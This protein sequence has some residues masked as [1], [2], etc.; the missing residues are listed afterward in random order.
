MAKTR[1]RTTRAR[2]VR[3]G[4]SRPRPI[5]GRREAFAQ[6]YVAHHN[7]ARAAIEAGYAR[8][9][10]KVTGA[11]LLTN[12]NLRM[13]IAELDG[14]AAERAELTA[15]EVR[16]R[17]AIALRVSAADFFE[18]G[19][20]GQPQ[21]RRIETWPKESVWALE[22]LKVKRYEPVLAKDGSVIR[23]AFEVLEFKLP[24]RRGML[25]LTGR[26]TGAIPREA[27]A[28]GDEGVHFHFHGGR[29]GF[30]RPDPER[31]GKMEI[32]VGKRDG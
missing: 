29:M 31:A 4:P 17:A 11:R 15:L 12:A 16:Q 13:R 14:A 6:A 20:N 1:R 21:F 23:D 28:G 10:A 9:S 24:S 5:S 18:T 25:E 7:A 27:P 22:S 2:Q 26:M 8:G 32:V 3:E 19:P 30:E